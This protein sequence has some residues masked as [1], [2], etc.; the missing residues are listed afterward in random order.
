MWSV[1]VRTGFCHRNIVMENLLRFFFLSFP[2]SRSLSRLLSDGNNT[3][4]CGIY[5]RCN[6]QFSVT[7]IASPALLLLHVTVNATFCPFLLLCGIQTNKILKHFLARNKLTMKIVLL[8]S[9]KGCCFDAAS[10]LQLTS[11]GSIQRLVMVRVSQM[12]ALCLQ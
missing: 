7:I 11:P 1:L 10:L 9:M 8:V 2:S 6:V 3:G 4:I 12:A 5:R